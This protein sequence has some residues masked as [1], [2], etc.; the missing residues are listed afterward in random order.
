[1]RDISGWIVGKH[2][3]I[4]PWATLAVVVASTYVVDRHW[5]VELVAARAQAAGRAE[6]QSA[7]WG[8]AISSAISE[9]IGALAAARMRFTP[10]EDAVSDRTFAAALDSV[11][12]DLEGLR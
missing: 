8:D 9:R 11:T 7:E 4:F 5:Q 2:G 10:I 3:W 1:M 12:V 6:A